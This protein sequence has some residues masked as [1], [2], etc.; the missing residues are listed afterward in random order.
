MAVVV[1]TIRGR[2]MPGDART[3]SCGFPVEEQLVVAV[4][5]DRV[6]EVVLDLG[7][8]GAQSAALALEFLA[9]EASAADALQPRIDLLRVPVD[10]RDLGLDD[11]G[12]S[13]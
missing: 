5:A 9:L 7:A 11:R 12:E 13:D 1:G 4:D 8:E 2:P 6:G 10:L 3:W